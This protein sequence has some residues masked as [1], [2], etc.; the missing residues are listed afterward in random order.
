M[1]D[2]R[3]PSAPL[4]FAERV[5][6]AE[7]LGYRLRGVYVAPDVYKALMKVASVKATTPIGVVAHASMPTCMG[8][9]IAIDD[10]LPRGHYAPMLEDGR[11]ASRPFFYLMPEFH[12]G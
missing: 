6:Q 9:V 3:T 1:A 4:T 2:R 12:D 11:G 5:A 10:N 7:E 8:L